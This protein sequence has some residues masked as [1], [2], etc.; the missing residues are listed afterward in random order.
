MNLRI[1][2]L[3]FIFGFLLSCNNDEVDLSFPA[4]L[5]ELTADNENLVIKMQEV[6]GE[7]HFWL[8]TGFN[9]FDADEYIVDENCDTVCYYGGWINPECIEDY[10]GEWVIIVN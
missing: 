10:T 4:C 9:A 8:N 6:D 5:E 7:R 3:L 2:L 1:V